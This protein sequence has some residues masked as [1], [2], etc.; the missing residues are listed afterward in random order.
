MKILIVDDSRVARNCIK[1]AL[2]DLMNNNLIIE[3]DDGNTAWTAIKNEAPDLIFTDW[4]ME[5]MDGLELIK[6]VRA[7]NNHVKICMLTSETNN[8]QQALARSEGADYILNKP[9]KTEELAK[10]LEKLLG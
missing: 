6:K 3:A 9:F 7:S 1:K 5:K 2:S 8:A 10:A 4:Y